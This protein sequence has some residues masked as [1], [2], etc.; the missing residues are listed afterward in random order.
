[1]QKRKMPAQSIIREYWQVG[2]GLNL[3]DEHGIEITDLGC[4]ACGF[5][6]KIERCHIVPKQFGG[7][8]DVSNLHLLCP[9]CHAES[10]NLKESFYW[11]WLIVKNQSDYKV[12]ELR[13]Y[14]RQKSLG[15]NSKEISKLCEQGLFIQAAEYGTQHL[16]SQSDKSIQEL[17][18]KLKMI[19]QA[20]TP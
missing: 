11:K 5:D 7:Q 1:M 19:Y 13:L 17:A 14:E 20:K 18:L 15:I 6:L 12:S 3:L 16:S 2:D 9:N 4:F 10:E 8:D